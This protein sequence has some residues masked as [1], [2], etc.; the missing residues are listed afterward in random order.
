MD[1]L[2]RKTFINNQT[3]INLFILADF[4]TIVGYFDEFQV[5]DEIISAAQVTSLYQTYASNM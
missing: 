2:V 1:V 4:D 3:F 5:W